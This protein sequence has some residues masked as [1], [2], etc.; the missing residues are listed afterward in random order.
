MNALLD[1]FRAFGIG[2]LAAIFGLA[3]GVAAALVY[4]SGNVGAGSQ[5]LLYSG[6]DPAAAA[7]AAQLLDQA[8]VEYEIKEG[9]TA[10][11]VPRDQVDEA[12]V[13]VAS[14][15][16]LSGASVGYEIFDREDSFG[17]TSFVQNLNAKRALEGEL[18]RTIQSMAFVSAARVHLNLPERRLFARDQ[19]APTAAVTISTNG[20]LNSEQVR[21]IRNIVASG[22]GI[23]SNHV[24]LADDRGRQLAGTGGEGSAVSIMMD[25]RQSGIEGQLRQNILDLV[26]GVVGVGAARV[27]V[28]AELNRQ[29]V[30]ESS[31]TY[32]PDG[33]VVQSRD[34]RSETSIDQDGANSNRVSASENLPD[35]E[36]GAGAAAGAT[37]NREI[38]N[39]VVS[40]A[41][42]S[43]TRTQITEAGG[44]ERL[45]VAVA[46]DGI[47][48]T[49]PD[50]TV[51]WRERSQDEIDRIEA[52]VRSA[53]GYVNEVGGRQDSV[54]VSQME[55][56]RADPLLGTPAASGLSFSKSDIM[57]VAEIA[58]MFITALLVIFLVARPLIKGAGGSAMPAGLALAGAT[59]GG[60]A[61]RIDNAAAPMALAGTNPSGGAAAVADDGIDISK[62]DGQV[63]ASSVKKVASIVESHPEESISILRTWLHEG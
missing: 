11:Y 60:G 59:G 46:V 29:S 23:E 9:G 43:T 27:Q 28:T 17:Q 22:A 53:M 54:T 39:D 37:S 58:V 10:I 45:S 8:N 2:R 47:V 35:A 57:R 56:A 49:Q 40:Y 52:L 18:A 19:Q 5:S 33:A 41:M 15:G 50:G 25:E 51:Q 32:D 20:Q 7:S 21:V 61:P 38:S 13:R 34:R 44:I 30:T 63:K 36:S 26:E 55:F 24:S 48:E 16:P 31:E 42:S 14:G 12:R 4:F 3:A 1:Q 6:L 62:I